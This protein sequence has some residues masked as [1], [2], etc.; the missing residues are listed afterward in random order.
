MYVA[1]ELHPHRTVAIKVF[2]PAVTARIGAE[3]FQREIALAGKLTHP[4]IVSVYGAGEVDGLLYYVMPFIEGET[5]R[6]RL[7]REHQLPLDDVTLIIRDVAD[8]LDHAHR[9][10][11]VHRDIKPQNIL[12]HEGR[13]F[14][15]DFGI[16]KAVYDQ[17]AQSLT[18][19]GHAVGT[20]EYMSPE[21]IDG[22]VHLD[23][24]S[25]VYAFACVIYEMLT[26]EP[27]FRGRTIQST[28]SRQLSGTPSPMRILRR[29]LP[30]ALDD[31]VAR[32]LAKSPNDRFAS[33][34]DFASAVI[35]AIDPEAVIRF[36]TP[37]GRTPRSFATADF[38]TR[39]RR[40]RI[41]RAGG[42][43][44]VV[45]GTA[46]AVA[47]LSSTS[48]APA[49]TTT[50]IRI[51]VRAVDNLTGSTANETA[52]DL[53]TAD[54]I[55]QLHHLADVEVKDRSS[56]VAL[57]ESKLT[58]RQFA[59]SLEVT[60]VIESDLEMNADALVLK[61]FLADSTGRILRPARVEWRANEFGLMKTRDSLVRVLIGDLVAG[62][63]RPV[64]LGP[65]GRHEHLLGHDQL[66][67]GS[68]QL[69]TRTVK[70][71]RGALAEFDAAIAMDPDYAEA[72]AELSK[73]YSVALVYRYRLDIDPY[74]AAGRA[75]AASD[76][77]IR[78][79]PDL[80]SGYSAR[81]FIQRLTMAP[82]VPTVASFDTAKRID[83]DAADAV[84]WSSPAL[85]MQGRLEEAISEAQRAIRLDKLSASRR[86]TLAV[87]SIGLRRYDE[88]ARSAAAARGLA[89][90]LALA[91]AWWA[92]ALILGGRGAECADADLGPHAG[93][94]ALCLRAAGRAGE[95]A[96]I[97][98]SLQRD[99]AANQLTDSTFTDVLRLEDLATY[100]AYAGNATEAAAWADRA[101][102]RAPNGITVEL[103]ESDLFS[104]VRS[105]PKF[106][107]V[108]ER[109][110][111]RAADR[112]QM[113]RETAAKRFAL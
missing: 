106:Q 37:T 57:R 55:A 84:G 7:D 14:V 8:A 66:L 19:E 20:P 24:R 80:A 38:V 87:V 90:E 111:R 110:R 83:P 96:S 50:A 31:V 76:R 72:Y 108:L 46:L 97:I 28:I 82:A 36:H 98:D 69:A 39:H 64:T 48:S 92:R 35:H 109:A 15:T 25:D 94:R 113:T 78:L 41:L 58:T 112:L 3:R 32:A 67:N 13:A 2:D 71:L 74:D 70:G 4:G 65:G 102:T 103:L 26:G 12:L 47:V 22:S 10:D 86:I 27:P 60:H 11:I 77:A 5:L 95:A 73:T 107:T 63:P 40:R 89:P 33:V 51:A 79:E 62:L 101:Y 18:E 56:S 105:D 68:R 93:L 17:P 99:A 42:A 52:V 9:R 54:L 75:L 53:L 61:A 16:A 29:T 45:A 1:T 104:P 21:Q 49:L 81:G 100:F 85:A 88:A 91:K 6:D 44:A 30:V 43:L 34:V 23:A 59:E